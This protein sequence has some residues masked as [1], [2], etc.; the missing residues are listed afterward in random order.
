MNTGIDPDRSETAP[1]P[2]RQFLLY[3][4]RL[5][6]FGFGG[7]IALAGYMQ[8]DLVEER[9]WIS[10]QD[11]AEVL[12][13]A[14]LSP[15]PLAAQLAMYLG[16]LRR[17]IFGATLTGAVFILPSFLMVLVLAALYVH[18]GQLVWIQ[19]IFYGIGASVIAIIARSAFQLV[20]ATLGRDW[21][22]WVLFSVIALTTAWTE[23][24]IVWLFVFCG[25]IAV[26]VE[27]PPRFVLRPVRLPSFAGLGWPLTGVHRIASLGTVAKVFL[28]FAKGAKR[29]MRKDAR[30]A[31]PAAMSA[32]FIWRPTLTR[33]QLGPN[34]RNSRSDCVWWPSLTW[35]A[36]SDL[37]D[38]S[39]CGTAIFFKAGSLPALRIGND[40]RSNFEKQIW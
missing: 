30:V 39:G 35:R 1:G 12:A 20:K 5:G 15:G 23:S 9:R 29:A 13:F 10:R 28:F 16:W 14:Q 11:Y 19:G 21:F 36:K 33:M 3:F 17:G 24:E 2:L 40:S 26:F 25:V 4:L 38:A 27:A 7:P 34:G 18:F 31:V 8:R 32:S 37:H 6:T 22:L